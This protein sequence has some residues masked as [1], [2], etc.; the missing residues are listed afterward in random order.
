MPTTAMLPLTLRPHHPA[1]DWT[2]P[3]VRM[4]NYSFRNDLLLALLPAGAHGERVARGLVE[5]RADWEGWGTAVLALR[6]DPEPLAGF[7]F[8][9]AH[10]AAGAVARLY[11]VAPEG[12]SGD[13]VLA[14]LDHRGRFM[15]GWRIPEGT[16]PDWR[17]VAETV[18]WVA[19]Q[20][21][22]CGACGVLEGWETP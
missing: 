3:E 5:H 22:E 6:R 16:E 15:D 2:L 9:Q 12:G 14:V 10:D 19:V 7:P 4:R 11:G 1:P 21:P 8:R 20:E 13:A 17:E 18:R